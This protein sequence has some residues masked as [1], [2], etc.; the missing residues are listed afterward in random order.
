M[1]TVESRRE[2]ISLCGERGISTVAPAVVHTKHN[3]GTRHH[4]DGCAQGN[5][6]STLHLKLHIHS[7]NQHGRVFGKRG[8]LFSLPLQVCFQCGAAHKEGC[9]GIQTSGRA[10]PGCTRRACTW[11]TTWVH[12]HTSS[13]TEQS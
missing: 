2:E 4:D 9:Q 11:Q 3:D 6:Y 10:R 1:C 8:R 13:S 5:R 12:P 7:H